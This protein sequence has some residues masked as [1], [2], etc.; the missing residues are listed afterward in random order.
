MSRY[1]HCSA[2]LRSI[3]SSLFLTL[4][5]LSTNSAHANWELTF[6]D[7]FNGSSLDTN[8]WQTHYIDGMLTNNDELEGYTADSFAS[9]GTDLRLIARKRT[10]TLSDG[11]T[12]NYTSGL[13]N[14]SKVFSQT[15]GYFEMRAKLPKGNGFWP[16][17]WLLPA[18]GAWPPEIDILE[19]QGRDPTGLYT[20]LH[21]L[22]NGAHDISGSYKVV[23]DL[24]AGYHTYGVDWQQGLII[25]YLDGIEVFRTPSS[26]ASFVPREPMYMVANLAVGGSW[27]GAPDASTVFPNYM[28]IDYIRAYKKVSSG[29]YTSIPRPSDPIPTPNP[30]NPN[31]QPEPE[32]PQEPP[33][34]VQ[35]QTIFNNAVPAVAAELSDRNAVELGMKFQ[36]SQAGTITGIRFYRA[37]D[38]PN[39]F[40]ARL[41]SANGTLMG[42]ATVPAGKAMPG[43]LEATFAQ[44]VQISA[45]TTYVASYYSS[46]G[47]YPYQTNG[48]ANAV[49]NGPLTAL[50]NQAS[51]GNGV[52]LYGGGFP[53]QSY[54]GSNYY[55]D[56][57][58]SSATAPAPDTQSPSVPAGLAAT[59]ISGSQ[60]NLSW[61]ASSDNVGVTGYKIYRNGNLLKQVTGTSTSDTGLAAGMTYSYQISA[62][63]AAGNESLNSS[64]VSATTPAPPAPDTQAPSVPANLAGTAVSTAQINLSWS[65]SSDNVGVTG[66]KIYRN[67]SLLKQVTT[68]SSSDS[69]LAAGVSYSYQVSAIDAAGNESQSSSA[70][71]VSTLAPPAPDTQAPS[72]PAGLVASAASTSQ[73]NLSWSA[74]SDNVGVTGYRIYRDGSLLKLVTSLSSNDTG[75]AASTSYS[76]QISA[77]DAAGN[78]SAKSSAVSAVTQT[79]APAPSELTVLGSRIPA[80]PADTDPNAVELGVKFRSTVAGKIKGIRF[81]RSAASSSG[82]SVYLYN[83]SGTRMGTASIAASAVVLPGYVQ[84]NFATPIAIAANTTYTASYF[85]SNGRYAYELNAMVNAISNSTLS[86]LAGSS[87]GGNGVYRYG[88]AGGTRPTQTYQNSN[89]FVDV[90]FTP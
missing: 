35:G 86:F 46:N 79:P 73:I 81:Y 5:L 71:S 42:T 77:I 63:D 44:P 33:P 55:V 50:G 4:C 88:S 47:Q 24:T 78:E 56:V 54:Q 1:Q 62:I 45:G 15:Y 66:Y 22:R 68:T 39:G 70:I 51:G 2:S 82:F 80:N 14:S 69:G 20:T 36:S 75:L 37:V 41:Y 25:W 21:F 53:N 84:V 89:Y 13:I 52:Y 32:E 18:T 7:E 72:V 90:V 48:F 28:D 38:N 85:A 3:V 76:Y 49:S 40:V 61:S 9:T 23:A 74:A 11:R 6:S 31:P 10:M 8:T 43:W 29:G 87:N 26:A 30:Q 34:A 27:V 59:A 57:R 65:A 17:F 19:H 67:G 16:A 60:I 58:F 83:S 12:Y 64:A